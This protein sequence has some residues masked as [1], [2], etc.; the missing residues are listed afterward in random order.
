MLA[1]GV[2]IIIKLSEEE[3]YYTFD[4]LSSYFG[5]S[6]RLI[7]YEVEQL[8]EW[9]ISQALLTVEIKRSL[10]IQMNPTKSYFEQLNK[11]I[12]NNW[13]IESL[14]LEDRLL[15][16]VL[17]ILQ[18]QGAL[19][20]KDVQSWLRVSKSTLDQDIRILRKR[21]EQ[22]E[23][24][25]LTHPKRGIY[26][27]G[28]ES[29]IRLM[30]TSLIN[31]SVDSQRMFYRFN[32]DKA[33]LL[34]EQEL[35]SYINMQDVSH[36]YNHMVKLHSSIIQESYII[37]FSICAALSMRRLQDGFIVEHTFNAYHRTHVFEMLMP[38]FKLFQLPV[39]EQSFLGLLIDG[40]NLQKNTQLRE[41]WIHIQIIA[42][43]L[44]K[45]V[46]ISLG[47]NIDDE[48]LFERLF[49]HLEALYKRLKQGITVFNPLTSLVKEHYPTTFIAVKEAL[50]QLEQYC[51]GT[52]D[53]GEIAYVAMYFCATHEK[54]SQERKVYRLLVVCGQGVATSELIVQKLR[55][56]EVFDIV[57]IVLSQDLSAVI[58]MDIDLIVKT[59][60]VE[61]SPIPSV[62]ISPICTPRDIEH[63]HDMLTH[64]KPRYINQ[65]YQPSYDQIMAVI[66]GESEEFAKKLELKIKALWQLPT[67]EKG[68]Q[69][70]LEDVLSYN[71]ILLN[72]SAKDWQEA[73]T[74]AATPL[75]NQGV[76]ESSYIQAMIDNVIEFGP[77]IVLT[78]GFA[79]AHAKPED[80]VNKLG[81]SVLTL[82]EPVVFNSERF[83]PVSMIIC[84]A[85]VD[86][87]SHM[88]IMSA[89]ASL[90]SQPEKIERLMTIED[91]ETF[92]KLLC[93]D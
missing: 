58:R 93:E 41:D 36:V 32:Q 20:I 3:R 21:F 38:L 67:N 24:Q 27:H 7:R 44:M 31:Q 85:A 71:Q 54:R 56:I 23:L 74:L 26:I 37:H 69:P 46:G 42:W 88:N 40:Y 72:Q 33:H 22:F 55:H 70:M 60:D 81:V 86:N 66:K 90:M 87:H 19:L 34:V 89:I 12:Y 13:Q 45:D 50:N 11:A 16:I 82:K 59:I 35:M 68:V 51:V 78:K 30:V 5:V 8:N 53:D 43:Q 4:E 29:S 25:L 57:G 47:L 17:K 84:L 80:G 28:N 65:T 92:K 10:G 75:L 79:L 18:S 63:I 14:K 6:K 48:E 73:I 83:D 2:D 91:Q 49:Y 77:Y 15:M 62:R 61:T 9:L 64:V 1:R 39:Q 76:I 52:L